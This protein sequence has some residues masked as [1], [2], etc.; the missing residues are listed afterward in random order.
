MPFQIVHLA[1]N[2]NVRIPQSLN[3]MVTKPSTQRELT[4]DFL[5]TQANE[6]CSGPG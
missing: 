3:T 1:F 2:R 4:N 6:H 5:D